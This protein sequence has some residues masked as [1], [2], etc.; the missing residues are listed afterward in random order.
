LPECVKAHLA[1]WNFNFFSGEDPDPCFLG[2]A[3]GKAG[4]GGRRKG[5]GKCWRKGW[6]REGNGGRGRHSPKQKFT[7]TP[8]NICKMSYKLYALPINTFA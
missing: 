2:R 5:K 3:K 4:N 1:T 8:L 7:T 6:R